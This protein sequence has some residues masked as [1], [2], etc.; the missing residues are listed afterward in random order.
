[1]LDLNG[2]NFLKGYKTYIIATLLVLVSLVHLIT[3]DIGIFDF[4]QSPDLLI[5]LNGLGLGALRSAVK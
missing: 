3:G 2:M 1:M 5:L 4:V